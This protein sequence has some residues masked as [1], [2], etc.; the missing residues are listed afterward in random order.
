MIPPRSLNLWRFIAGLLGMT[1]VAMAAVGAHAV[2]DLQAAGSVERASLYQLL[3]ALALLIST[4]WA[5]GIIRL[6]RWLMLSGIFLFSG[7]IY[8]KYLFNIP[9]ATAYAPTGGTLLMLG[10]LGFSLSGF[11]SWFNKPEVTR[12]S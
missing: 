7:S 12:I 6:S 8:L 4:F 11:F 2:T 10:W 9:N 3:H 1:A 5:G